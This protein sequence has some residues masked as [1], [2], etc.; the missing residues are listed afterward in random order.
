MSERQREIEFG[1]NRSVQVHEADHHLSSNGG[2]LVLREFDHR[3]GL[4]QPICQQLR[5]PRD[6]AATTYS[7]DELTRT[8]LMQM[9]L[10]HGS[11]T[12]ADRLRDDAA[13]RLA[14]TDQRGQSAIER[15]LASQP[16]MSRLITALATLPNRR[17]L[18]LA[19]LEMAIRAFPL[20]RDHRHR[21]L[22]LDLDSTDIETHGHQQAANY[23]GYYGHTCYHPLLASLA[24][25]GDLCGMWL[26][27]GNASSSR[28]T[29]AFV[30][31][32]LDRLA[33]RDSIG[34]IVD[35][36]FDAAF[37]IPAVMDEL[38]RRDIRFVGRIKSNERLEELAAP[39]L[40]RPVGRPPL[41]RREWYHEL[42]YGA[43]S[44]PET[45]RVVLVIVD[46]PEDRYLGKP[47]LRH[48]FLVTSHSAERMPAADLV[49][50]YRQRGTFESM[51]GE[52][53]NTMEPKLSS[54]R[55]REN[56]VTLSLCAIAYQWLH[57]LRAFSDAAEG[58]S[59]AASGATANAATAD[60]D[61]AGR[62]RRMRSRSSLATIRRRLLTVAVRL[63]RSGRYVH[64][65]LESAACG[66]WQRLLCR[67]TNRLARLTPPPTVVSA[68]AHAPP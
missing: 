58:L 46:D 56:A 20:R 3:L 26:R 4:L 30:A 47:D 61:S 13:L 62:T 7:L 17:V 64:V 24:E 52:F 68:T 37:A 28:G 10:G 31:P 65:W 35:V 33:Q 55:W 51:I 36:R 42:E 53:K 41:H 54:P 9:A 27:K 15:E 8:R 60:D 1:F 19:P 22:T 12:D 57:L 6:P 66:L 63:T 23:N 32:I 39:W 21:Y 18:R 48:Y 16:T 44:W 40:G 11:Q 38:D 43:Q 2:A 67:V 29:A 14:I 59:Q 50:H 25:T 5:D 34:Q 45:R 49:A